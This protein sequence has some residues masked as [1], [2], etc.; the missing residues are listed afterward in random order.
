MLEA[1]QPPKFQ[2]LPSMLTAADSQRVRVLFGPRVKLVGQDP[3]LGTVTAAM[4]RKQ[5]LLL[6]APLALEMVRRPSETVTVFVPWIHGV[7]LVWLP[8]A[9]RTPSALNLMIEPK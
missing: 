8:L 2:S 9:T 4:S 6:L 1:N 3:L 7:V 5:S